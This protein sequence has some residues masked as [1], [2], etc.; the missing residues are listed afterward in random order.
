MIID[1]STIVRLVSGT[2]Y[3]LFAY[4]DSVSVPVGTGRA[5]LGLGDRPS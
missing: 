1:K 4:T 2:I 3:A 5:S